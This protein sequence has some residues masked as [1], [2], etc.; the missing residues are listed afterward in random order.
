MEYTIKFI[1]ICLCFIV[2]VVSYGFCFSKRDCRYLIS[3][4]ALTVVSDFFLVYRD[5]DYRGLYI[6]FTVHAAYTLRASRD[7]KRG[8]A[9]I[10]VIFICLAPL[11]FFIDPI[12]AAAVMYAC[13]F[14]VNLAANVRMYKSKNGGIPE[15]NKKII[16]TGL[17]TFLLCDVSVIL[18]NLPRYYEV[19]GTVTETAYIVMWVFYLSSQ[20]LL[21]ISGFKFKEK[22]INHI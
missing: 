20:L 4:T 1:F 10:T 9:L 21:S 14:A 22:I 3:A 2:S 17:I 11:Y 19:R 6:F 15:V 18:F 16:L 7:K 13:F 8:A 12:A 5:M